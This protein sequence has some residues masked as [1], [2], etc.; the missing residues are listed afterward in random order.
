MQCTETYTN[1]ERHAPSS[2]DVWQLWM[3]IFAHRPTEILETHT[4]EHSLGLIDVSGL[5]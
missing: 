4:Q 1:M 5:Q 2:Q 3:Q